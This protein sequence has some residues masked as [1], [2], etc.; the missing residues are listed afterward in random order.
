MKTKQRQQGSILKW[1]IIIIAVI[2]LA[3]FF[4]DFSVQE[5]VEDQQT[6]ENFHYIWS[7]LVSFY[8]SYLSELM[9]K[10][11]NFFIQYVWS[12]LGDGLAQLIQISQNTQ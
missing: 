6:Q 5:V 8:N 10:L 1:I 7:H 3:S 4:F 9:N 2:A 11:W 12:N